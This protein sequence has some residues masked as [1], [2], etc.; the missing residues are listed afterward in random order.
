EGTK[1]FGR[2]PRRSHRGERVPWD[3]WDARPQQ[4]DACKSENRPYLPCLGRWDGMYTIYKSTI[5]CC[6]AADRDA[7]LN[8]KGIGTDHHLPNQ[9]PNYSLLLL[10]L[11]ILC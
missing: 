4:W 3:A 5:G 9:Q 11:Q 2:G 1:V 10:H 6:Y 8:P 7:V